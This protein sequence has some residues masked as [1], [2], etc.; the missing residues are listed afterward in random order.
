M[1]K[2][3]VVLADGFEEIEALT[4]IDV[5]RRAK[6]EVTVAGVGSSVILGAHGVSVACDCLVDRCR[7][8]FDCVVCPGGMP[9]AS[10]LASCWEVNEHLIRTAASG[11]LVAAIC[12]APA[13]VLGPAGLLEGHEAV[14]YPGM[15]IAFPEFKF[16]DGR[17]CVSGNLITSRGPGCAMEFALAIAEYLFG[18]EIRERLSESLLVR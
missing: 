9:G 2:V 16:G 14:C 15:E 5:L 4:P 10:N 11:G 12:A 3:L 17:V 18:K 7:G 8:P 1:K 13:V 6:A